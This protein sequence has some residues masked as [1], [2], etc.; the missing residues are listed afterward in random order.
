MLLFIEML[1]WILVVISIFFLVKLVKYFILFSLVDFC[2][3]IIGEINMINNVDEHPI[4]QYIPYTYTPTS[5]SRLHLC[6]HLCLLF[7][8]V[9]AFLLLSFCRSFDAYLSLFCFFFLS[10]V[11]DAVCV[12]CARLSSSS[13]SLMKKLTHNVKKDKTIKC[14]NVNINLCTVNG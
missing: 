11:E 4:P 8:S 14:K 7:F 5:R 2:T 12:V 6:S 3:T 9:V 1:S 10:L 13:W